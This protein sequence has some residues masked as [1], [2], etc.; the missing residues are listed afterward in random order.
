MKIIMKWGRWKNWKLMK[1]DCSIELFLFLFSMKNENFCF[2]KELVKNIMREDFGQIQFVLIQ[3]FEKIMNKQ[4]K[5]D[6]K[7][8]WDLF[9]LWKKRGKLFT[10]YD[11]W[12]EI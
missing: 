9:V 5:E 2:K 10:M 8:R 3:D 12:N 4:P 6:Y 11:F 1:N 7:K